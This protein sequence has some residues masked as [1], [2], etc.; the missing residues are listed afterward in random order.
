MSAIQFLIS[1]GMASMCGDL[2]DEERK[3]IATNVKKN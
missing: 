2:P 3:T 1:R